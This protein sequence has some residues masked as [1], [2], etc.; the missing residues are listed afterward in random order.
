MK[1]VESEVLSTVST[2][3]SNPQPPPLPDQQAEP[4]STRA[5]VEFANDK[6]AL[7]HVGCP[8]FTEETVGAVLDSFSPN[9]TRSSAGSRSQQ[10]PP[11]SQ[12][13][14]SKSHIKL[15][16]L[17]T[18]HIKELGALKVRTRF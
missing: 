11:S 14:T 16:D 10:P 8:P 17:Q 7:A 4:G 2:I 6:A 12:P 1:D 15:K 9:P 5:S 13:I 18:V 3:Y